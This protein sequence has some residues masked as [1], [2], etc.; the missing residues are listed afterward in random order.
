[1][2][3]SFAT[4]WIIA[5]QVSLS[6]GFPRQEYWGGLSFPS[7]VDLPNPG[8]EPSL[9]HCRLILY[10]WTTWEALE[11]S[12]FS[13]YKALAWGKALQK[14]ADCFINLQHSL[15]QTHSQN[16]TWMKDTA[17]NRKP[18]LRRVIIHPENIFLTF[19]RLSL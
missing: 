9:L 19:W 7:P 15:L 18:L 16:L 13:L 2:F 8:K 11:D 6:M 14:D 1:M 12:Y 4:P 5:R 10:H 3:N 17:L